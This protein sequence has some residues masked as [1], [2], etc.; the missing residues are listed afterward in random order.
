MSLGL[1]MAEI[2]QVDVSGKEV[3]RREAVARGFIKLRPETI[4]RIK[5]GALEKGDPL[6]VARLAGINA[7]KLTPFLLP[8]CHPLKLEHVE[9]NLSVVDD[10]VEVV[11]RVVAHEK[12][13]VEMEALTAAAIA[14]LNIWDVVKQYEKDE[15]GQY[16]LT[17]ITSIRVLRK[18]KEG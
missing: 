13:G 14:L 8:L 16:P 7:A 15:S 3:I 2:R 5:S 1:D 10:G 6:Q 17:E 9:V 11:V 12:T 4:Q 18:I